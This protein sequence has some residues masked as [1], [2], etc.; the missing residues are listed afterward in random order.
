MG[1]F[2]SPPPP[3]LLN[4]HPNSKNERKKKRKFSS[5]K[6]RGGGSS[7]PCFN[8]KK[9]GSPSGEKKLKKKMRNGGSYI[10]Y[11]LIACV[12]LAGCDG[13]EGYSIGKKEYLKDQVKEMFGHAW[14]GYMEYAFP[15]D[16]LRPVT[17]TK[18]DNFGG[19]AL[20]VID[21]LDTLLIMG[22]ATE[23]KEMSRWISKNIDFKK[24]N[25]RV[26][27]FETV[28]RVLGG[29]LAAHAAAERMGYTTADKDV[30]L[31]QAKV[32]ADRLLE[33]FDTPTGVPYNEI[34]LFTGVNHG[35]GHTT[36]PAAAGTLLLEFGV[37]TALTDDCRYLEVAHRAMDGV[38]KFRSSHNLV[39]TILD[40]YNGKWL[41][42]GADIGA[43]HDSFFEYM[44]KA[45]ILFNDKHWLDMWKV[46]HHAAAKHLQ[47]GGNWYTKVNSETTSKTDAVI[48]SLQAFW[49]GLL[50]LYGDIDGAILAFRPFEC[51][52][53]TLGFIPEEFKIQT[54]GVGGPGYPLRP[55]MVESAWLLHRATGDDRYLRFGE[56]LLKR[57][58]ATARTRC[59]FAAVKD[60]RTKVLEDKMDSYMLSET[61]KYLYLLFS[62]TP[63]SYINLDHTHVLNTEAHPFPITYEINE[64]YKKCKPTT[65]CSLHDSPAACRGKFRYQR[66]SATF[67]QDTFKRFKDSAYEKPVLRE[68]EERDVCPLKPH[69]MRIAGLI[70]NDGRCFP[71]QYAKVNL[72]EPKQAQEKAEPP[73]PPH[74]AIQFV[75]PAYK[76]QNDSKVFQLQVPPAFSPEIHEFDGGL[77]VKGIEAHTLGHTSTAVISIGM[78]AGP[79]S[80]SDILSCSYYLASTWAEALASAKGIAYGKEYLKQH[81]TVPTSEVAHQA[82]Q[83]AQTQ[84]GIVMDE[85]E[86]RW[87]G[88]F[89]IAPP[90]KA[91]LG[92]Q[93]R[94]RGVIKQHLCIKAAK[95]VL[96]GTG[97][98]AGELVTPL[99]G[100]A[101]GVDATEV[102]SGAEAPEMVMG[103]TWPQ[104]QHVLLKKWAGV[105]DGSFTCP[106]VMA[107]HRI[108][109]NTAT[110]GTKIDP[111]MHLSSQLVRLVHNVNGCEEYVH[112]QDK[113]RATGKVLLIE[114]GG[115]TFHEKAQHAQKLGV[116]AIIILNNKNGAPE[117]MSDYP[118]VSPISIPLAMV[119][120]KDGVILTKHAHL[121]STATI[122]KGDLNTGPLE[123]YYSNILGVDSPFGMVLWRS[124]RPV[125][126]FFSAKQFHSS[127]LSVA[128]LNAAA[129]VRDEEFADFHK[130]DG[131][132][133]SFT[134]AHDMTI[135]QARDMLKDDTSLVAF[136]CLKS[137][138]EGRGSCRFST[139][140]HVGVVR[141]EN[142]VTYIKQSPEEET[143]GDLTLP[144]EG[145]AVW[146]TA[147]RVQGRAHEAMASIVKKSQGWT[148]V[149]GYRRNSGFGLLMMGWESAIQATEFLN[150]QQEKH[151]W[152]ALAT[153]DRLYHQPIG[154]TGSLVLVHLI[155]LKDTTTITQL[156][157]AADELQETLEVYDG[158]LGREILQT[159]SLM[160]DNSQYTIID[161]SHW[162]DVRSARMAAVSF[163]STTSSLYTIA[164]RVTALESFEL[165]TADHNK[166]LMPQYPLAGGCELTWKCD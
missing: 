147:G 17:C 163:T 97:L 85:T 159:P 102:G 83:Y 108:L 72:N 114:R 131:V 13:E 58:N 1:F 73:K 35:Q 139:E 61:L 24:L 54:G 20:T 67:F 56:D 96:T 94:I 151:V 88:L 154:L 47:A 95:E 152:A 166:E 45:Y 158:Y 153:V 155:S 14:G 8:K 28:I 107:E 118:S 46:A 137:P 125:P 51:V 90:V 68:W 60:V 19:Y 80:S 162:R 16:E 4:I 33:A 75:V 76:G 122:R 136:S 104:E 53:K 150:K 79:R 105:N 109:A 5:L 44:L 10:V 145:S 23:F 6:K 110:F 81:S 27:V 165:T 52:F 49:P 50:V 156:Y 40:I 124:S 126:T 134:K 74:K 111:Q 12:T 48:N 120:K 106:E 31:T 38:W 66:M 78:K 65:P 144:R 101:L 2:F 129:S 42:S 117:M 89:N 70:H 55:E 138:P 64:A 148:H 135:L 22:N 115:C 149:H 3:P 98:A 160:H 142:W 86:N 29:L 140:R 30:L 112:Q 69:Y 11:V 21:S 127:L 39:G 34:N 25:R 92:L 63:N 128:Y 164:E 93:N 121:G 77:L 113:Q 130:H 143:E 62:S 32:L 9:K 36:C 123:L 15:A 99:S 119:A 71:Y 18:N 146:V 7:N 133:K 37:L 157:E 103:S 82:C 141:D 161:V 26:S 84:A 100:L 57:L 91:V 132:I 59:G 116:V 87:K 43:S 41:H